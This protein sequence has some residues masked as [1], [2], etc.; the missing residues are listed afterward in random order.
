[1]KIIETYKG[2]D[3]K[4]IEESGRLRFVFEGSEREVRYLFEAKQII[5]EPIWEDCNLEGYFVDGTFSDYIGKARAT[6]KDKKSGKPDWKFMGRYDRDYK[7]PQSWDKQKV[8]PK[9]P[10]NDKTYEEWDVQR[11]VIHD[12][13]LK[14]KKIISSL[15]SS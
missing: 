4:Y 10:I 3:I 8:Y 9:N 11:N 13:G 15:K 14:G 1:M 2:V 12:E 6:R 7:D 5:D